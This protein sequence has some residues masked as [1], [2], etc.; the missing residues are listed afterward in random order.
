MRFA[1]LTHLLHAIDAPAHKQLQK[2]LQSPYFK[3]LPVEVHLYHYLIQLPKNFTE[4]KLLPATVATHHPLLKTKNAQD[5][6][7]TA[8]LKSIADFLGEEQQK[9][10][11][12]YQAL[13]RLRAFKQ[14]HLFELFEEHA[15]RLH[16]QLLADPAQDIDTLEA[17]HLLAELES[18]GFDA[19]LNPRKEYA[20][21][22]VLDTLDE[23]HAIKKLT[24]I[25]EAINRK[26]W[27]GTDLQKADIE[28][29]LHT[30][31]PFTTAKY[32]YVYLLV[33]IVQMQL[34]PTYQEG[35]IYYT[36]LRKFTEQ[37]EKQRKPVPSGAEFSVKA[38]NFCLRW[39]NGGHTQAGKEYMWW[40][41]WRIKH[42]LLL[43]NNLLQPT[44]FRNITGIAI[45]SGYPVQWVKTFIDK[46]GANLPEHTRSGNMAYAQALYLYATKNYIEAAYQFNQ[47]EAKNEPIYNAT[48]RRWHFICT[49]QS[50]PGQLHLDSSLHTFE[51]YLQR[52]A[53][54]L[55]QFRPLFN[56]FIHYAKKL[57][58]KPTKEMRHKIGQQLEAEE[59]FPGKDWLAEMLRK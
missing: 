34:A 5:K 4:K 10:Q 41:E 53:D 38:L 59:F 2:Y 37:L 20:L 43:Q 28:Q 46:Y 8:L 17:R 12:Y 51:K 30:L 33:Q 15:A 22:K 50:Q 13:N 6:A 47:A 21:E 23:Y 55:H 58:A 56:Q 57:V 31:T 24:Y 44:A 29:L 40:I 26:Q 35:N 42:Q 14:Y 9:R 54:A 25:S 16:A 1:K 52:H 18:N 45:K 32:P 7:A 36:A 49:Y 39:N 27:F 3:I 19:K 48:L 11:P